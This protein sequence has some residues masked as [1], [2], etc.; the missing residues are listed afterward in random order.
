MA[1]NGGYARL[2]AT[3]KNLE[4]GYAEVLK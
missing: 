1:R 4:E 2:Y 3:Q